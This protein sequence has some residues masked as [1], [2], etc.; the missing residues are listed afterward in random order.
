MG[1][2]IDKEGIVKD[3]LEDALEK[4]SI[5]LECKPTQVFIMIKPINDDAEFKCWLYTA[6]EG[7]PKLVREVSLKEILE[8]K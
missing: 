7:A 8:T 6:K 5:E 2:L 3:T 4:F 1:G